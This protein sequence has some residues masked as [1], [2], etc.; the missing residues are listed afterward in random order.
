VKWHCAFN[1]LMSAAALLLPLTA[2]P[3]SRIE[4][5][6]ASS[7]SS[8]T[9]HVNFKVVIPQVLYL[10]VAPANDNAADANT[11][12]IMSTGHT[13]TLNATVRIPDSNIPARR[14]V[15]LNAAART[16]IA[17]DAQCTLAPA[18]GGAPPVS[19]PGSTETGT[20]AVICTASMP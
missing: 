16:A 1:G 11:V 19:S 9:A 15:I 14:N 4:S 8:T 10:H 12:G 2:V 20:R 5:E 3:E 18:P 7:V 17:Q 13:V 6:S